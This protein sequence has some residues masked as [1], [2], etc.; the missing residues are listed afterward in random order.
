MPRTFSGTFPGTFPGTFSGHITRHIVCDIVYDI[1]YDVAYDIV[2][3]IIYD[4]LCCPPVLTVV[5]QDTLCLVALY[6]FRMEPLE[7]FDQLTDFDM[8]CGDDGTSGLPPSFQPFMLP[9][10]KRSWQGPADSVLPPR[11]QK[12]HNS[13]IPAVRGSRRCSC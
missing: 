3:Y 4:M 9:G 2:Y 8:A 1:V 13:A 11:G 5:W 7:D 12:Q 10:R 6:P